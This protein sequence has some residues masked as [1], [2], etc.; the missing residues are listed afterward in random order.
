[1]ANA[2]ITCNGVAGCVKK[3]QYEIY[4]G[5]YSNLKVVFHDT[6]QQAVNRS[7]NPMNTAIMTQIDADLNVTPDPDPEV[8][9]R[10]YSM[11]LYL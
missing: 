2:Y 7:F 9:Q 3:S 8:R 11:G 6:L 1:M 10:W 5:F 4:N